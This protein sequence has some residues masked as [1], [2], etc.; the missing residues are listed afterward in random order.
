MWSE[1]EISEPQVV[2]FT[3]LKDHRKDSGPRP[4]GGQV[5]RLNHESLSM[6]GGLSPFTLR[7][8]SVSD[9]ITLSR[10]IKSC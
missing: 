4:S 10:E 6:R 5:F 9:Q 2:T 8:C 7:V 3:L 1:M